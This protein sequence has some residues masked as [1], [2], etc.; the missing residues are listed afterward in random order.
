MYLT[1]TGYV[2]KLSM[3]IYIGGFCNV[4]VEI[5]FQTIRT[6][7]GRLTLIVLSSS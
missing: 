3:S 6:T 1:Y 7:L 4:F 2:L 5:F